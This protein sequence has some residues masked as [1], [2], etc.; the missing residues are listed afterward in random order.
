MNEGN[1]Q[2]Y[3]AKTAAKTRLSTSWNTNGFVMLHFP[4]Y[5]LSIYQNG[6]VS[7]D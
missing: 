6:N 5:W 1:I 3:I 4:T 2:F 7:R